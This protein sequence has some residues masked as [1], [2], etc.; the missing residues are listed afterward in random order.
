M[1]KIRISRFSSLGS[2]GV[3]A[4]ILAGPRPAAAQVDVNPQMPNVLLLVDNSGSMEYLSSSAAYPN[5]DADTG[6][7][8]KSRWIELQEVL[9]G[10]I[11]DYSCR[12]VDRKTAEFVQEYSL[13]GI[14]PYDHSYQVPYHRPLSGSCTPA[15]G[16]MPSDAFEF[17]DTATKF[18]DIGSLS[19]TCST[20]SQAND[21]LLDIYLNQVRFGLMT[22]DSLPDAGTGLNGTSPDPDSGMEGLWSYFRGNAA[23]GKPVNCLADRDFEVGARNAGAPPWEGRLMPFGPSSMTQTEIDKKNEQI[24]KVLLTTRPYGATPIAGMMDD[25]RTFMTLD[26]TSTNYP[27]PVTDTFLACRKRV[28]VL[29]TDG[30]PNTDMRPDCAQTGEPNGVCP[31]PDTPEQVAEKLSK[32]SPPIKTFVVGF[33]VSTVTLQDLTQVNCE[34]MDNAALND[35]NGV[36]AQNPGNSPLQACCTLNRIAAAGGSTKA[37]FAANKDALRQALNAIMADILTETTSRTLPVFAVASTSQSSL[38]SG[39]RFYSSFVPQQLT[40][41]S[42]VLERKRIKCEKNDDGKLEVQIKDVDPEAGDDFAAN[43]NS[44]D[45][46]ERR[47]ISVRP[48]ADGLDVA[49]G[50]HD[51]PRH[52]HGG[53]R[54]RQLQRYAVRRGRNEFR[55]RN[56]DAARGHENRLTAAELLHRAR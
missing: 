7:D 30:E 34:T 53:R 32:L 12:R 43:V 8:T 41:W 35:N 13:D 52:R 18:R 23:R 21:G 29:L 25:A 11:N 15:P 4:A 14:R 22:F 27:G 36:C 5:C 16:L 28:V 44:G 19:S 39:F 45:G 20:W 55:E 49:P 31:Y 38:A 24:Q 3:A 6:E 50:P 37:H 47:F 54:A 42:G 10:T 46:P 40:L 17:P 51:P 48:D 56:G 9:T 2:C 33:A 1:K 26:D